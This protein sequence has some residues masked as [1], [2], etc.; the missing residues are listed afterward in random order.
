MLQYF[1]LPLWTSDLHYKFFFLCLFL[2]SP[3]DCQKFW[4]TKK[5]DK[6]GMNPNGNKVFLKKLFLFALIIITNF[7]CF[8]LLFFPIIIGMWT[9]YFSRSKQSC[10]WYVFWWWWAI[11][12]NPDITIIMSTR[13]LSDLNKW[14][15]CCVSFIF[16]SFYLQ[17][18]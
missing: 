16:I 8:S 11:H 5:R 10:C 6:Y 9:F 14:I 15:F 12:T 3:H 1:F 2:S 13:Q 7:L 17:K 4:I 18:W